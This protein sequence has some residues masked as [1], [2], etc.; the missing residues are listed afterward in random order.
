MLANSSFVRKTMC[1]RPSDD[2]ATDERREQSRKQLLEIARNKCGSHVLECLLA[3]SSRVLSAIDTLRDENRSVVEQF[4]VQ[5]TQVLLGD[6]KRVEID[7]YAVHVL[8]TLIKV[9]SGKLLKFVSSAT[10]Y[11]NR[12]FLYY[13]FRRYR[14]VR[15]TG[16]C[17]E[18]VAEQTRP[19]IV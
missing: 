4:V 5:L 14:D 12:V 18:T 6:L 13:Y 16:C 8:K 1:S 19:G 10:S 15:L 9:L 11:S 3:H 7:S 17:S 2:E